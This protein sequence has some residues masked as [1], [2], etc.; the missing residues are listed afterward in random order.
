MDNSIPH[1]RKLRENPFTTKKEIQMF[2]A[3]NVQVNPDMIKLVGDCVYEI[4]IGFVPNMRVPGR[5]YATPDMADFAF[6]ELNKW[7]KNRNTG[8]PSI[9]QIAFVAT[10]PGI[11]KYS[12]GMPDMHSGYGF[13]IGGVAA[14]DTCDP[15]CIISP[16]GVG[17]DINC[18][19]R[20]FTTHLT[21]EEVE[22]HKRE[23]VE[24]MY[25]YIPTGVGGKRKNFMK[26][27]DVSDILT[28]GAKWA[29]ENGYGV[30]EDLINCEENG[31]LS[32]AD[33]S[34]ITERAIERGN[35]QLGTLG[36]GNHYVE[37]QYIDEIYDEK[38]A[39]VMGLK[40]G[41]VVCMIHTGSRGL[42]HQVATDFINEM[43]RTC[44]N[45]NLPDK[46]LSSAPLYS[47]LG[48]RYLHSMG[49]AA[50]F[51]WCNRQIITHFARQAFKEVMKKDDLQMD[52][53]YDV[54]HNIAKLERHTIDGV[55][56]EFI[57]HRK[58]ATRSFG[59]DRTELPEKYKEIG[60]P[61][62]IGG[63]M[64]TGSYILVGTDEG[65]NSSFGSTCHGAGRLMSRTKALRDINLR[66]VKNNLSKKGVELKAA[67]GDTVIEEAP[68][69]YKDVDSVVDACD[70]VGVSKKVARLVP[71]GVI[72]G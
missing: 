52:L 9:M 69:T 19:V 11:T 20:C 59:P 63:S 39:E 49:A 28:K 38:A 7:I 61:V 41:E 42:G 6:D 18:G 71:L 30:P 16:G 50:N 13:S 4:P 10:L 67:N 65:T 53:I 25:K 31:C 43:E 56:R 58:G 1:W 62:L 14:F 5:F 60:Q 32:Y 8:L 45:P 48:Q 37:I 40:K 70:I 22:P 54:A 3:A 44:D 34:L 21:R 33:A 55:E 12:Y 68:E 72:K 26:R 23:L 15:R 51:A 24:A 36:A 35:G 17:Y 27:S 66:N 57:V 47:E 46:Q 64:G 29:V 2:N